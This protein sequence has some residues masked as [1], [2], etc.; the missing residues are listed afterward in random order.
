MLGSDSIRGIA[1]VGLNRD[2]IAPIGDRGE[3]RRGWNCNVSR[4]KEGKEK[5]PRYLNEIL[6]R[7]LIVHTSACRIPHKVAEN[8]VGLARGDIR[9]AH[10]LRSKGD[11]IPDW[12]IVVAFEVCSKKLPPWMRLSS[13][14]GRW[15]RPSLFGTHLGRT[16]LHRSPLTAEAGV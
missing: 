15:H 6:L 13:E 7:P 14:M 5:G 10:V 1:R 9:Y 16:P 12:R 8:V 3:R 4:C 11:E 2:S